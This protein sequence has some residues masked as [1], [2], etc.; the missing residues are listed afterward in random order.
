[1]TSTGLCSGFSRTRPQSRSG[2]GCRPSR[3]RGGTNASLTFGRHTRS[4]LQF[5]GI[6]LALFQHDA[7]TRNVRFVVH[8]ATEM[9]LDLDEPDDLER[10][11]RAV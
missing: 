6:R 10:L 9:A 11:R 3:G 2:G 7:E 4:I 8:H 5:G 1:V